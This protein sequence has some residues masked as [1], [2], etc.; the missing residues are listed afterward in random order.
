MLTEEG[1]LKSSYDDVISSV[2]DFFFTNGNSTL[3]G[4]VC[5]P[6]EGQCRKIYLIL[7]YSIRVSL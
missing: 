2:D 4:K 3:I 5:S 1:D 7:S 6:Q